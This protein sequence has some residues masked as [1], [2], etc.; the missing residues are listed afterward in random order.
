MW[1]FHDSKCDCASFPHLTL[2]RKAISTRIKQSK[3]LRKQLQVVAT[4]QDR[5]FSLFRCASCAEFWQ[6]GREWNFANE[7]Y[8]FRVPAITAEEWQQEHYQQPAAMMIYSAMM[9]QYYARSKFTPSAD[10]CAY[11]GCDERASS[12]GMLCQRH[13]VE[14]LQKSSVLPSPPKGRLFPPYHEKKPN[15]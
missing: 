5:G 8:L 6:S 13:Q 3:S 9:D 11:E 1:P 12:I 7:E 2:D 10:K 14:S 15:P 4:D